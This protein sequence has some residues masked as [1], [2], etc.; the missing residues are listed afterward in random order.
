MGFGGCQGVSRRKSLEDQLQEKAANYATQSKQCVSRLQGE[1]LDLEIKTVLK[2]SE[3]EKANLADQR[4]A[5][6][7]IKIG[8]DYQCPPRFWFG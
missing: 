6:F 1:I 4:A 7:P 3:L 2:K 5:N 8:I